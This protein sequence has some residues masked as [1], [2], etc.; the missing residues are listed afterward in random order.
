M[1]EVM[2]VWKGVKECSNAMGS[3][4]RDRAL[5]NN[6]GRRRK[7][8][9]VQ[10]RAG[11]CRAGRGRTSC[12]CMSPVREPLTVLAAANLAPPSLDR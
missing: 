1:M 8:I 4:I 7:R 11:Q 5:I 6:K 3:D 9:E 2:S 12:A 10:G